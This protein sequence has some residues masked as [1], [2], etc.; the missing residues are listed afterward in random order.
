[1]QYRVELSHKAEKEFSRL[2]KPVQRFLLNKL[3][4]LEASS[5]PLANAAKLVNTKNL[6]RH[7]FGDYRVIF[8]LEKG[9]TIVILLVLKVAHRKEIYQSLQ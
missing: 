4:L 6:Y 8:T 7:R 2:D 5:N 3:R 1:M 9:G